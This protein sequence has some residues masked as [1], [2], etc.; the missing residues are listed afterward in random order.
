MRRGFKLHKLHKFISKEKVKSV[1][2]W[3]HTVRTLFNLMAHKETPTNS[4]WQIVIM[5]H[6]S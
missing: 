5:T 1:I 6:K 2:I 3:H 4:N